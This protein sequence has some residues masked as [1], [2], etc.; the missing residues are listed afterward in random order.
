MHD[1]NDAGV[2]AVGRFEEVP[3][4]DHLQVV[5]TDLLGTIAGSYFALRH[6]H[7]RKEGPASCGA[8]PIDEP[9]DL[10]RRQV[11]KWLLLALKAEQSTLLAISLG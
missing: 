1:S 2:A 6:F 8:E 10:K 3:L 5:R 9:A 7:E 11:A 4:A